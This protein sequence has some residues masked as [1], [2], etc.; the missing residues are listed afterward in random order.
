MVVY[1]KDLFSPLTRQCRACGKT[2]KSKRGLIIHRKKQGTTGICRKFG[3]LSNKI[4]TISTFKERKE[5]TK[6][7]CPKKI[8]DT[9]LESEVA[10]QLKQ[11]VKYSDLA[12]KLCINV[13]QVSLLGCSW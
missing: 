6:L 13:I 12:K 4:S 8:K 5:K 7:A 11:G 1:L 10:F 3:D 2:F 9:L